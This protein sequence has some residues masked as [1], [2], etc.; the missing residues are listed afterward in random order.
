MNVTNQEI[1]FLS[2]S[3]NK[4]GLKIPFH[5]QSEKTCMCSLKK[6][7]L[8]LATLKYVPQGEDEGKEGCHSHQS[9]NILSLWFKIGYDFFTGFKKWNVLGLL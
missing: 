4:K 2:E 8:E 1:N 7:V 6:D 3:H 5:K 9:F